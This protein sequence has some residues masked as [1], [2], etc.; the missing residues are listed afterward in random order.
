MTMAGAGT[1]GTLRSGGFSFDFLCD[2]EVFELLDDEEEDELLDE[3][4]LLELLE[5]DDGVLAFLA[6]A[7]TGPSISSSNDF[8]QPLMSL[9]ISR[10]LL[11]PSPSKWVSMFDFLLNF[12]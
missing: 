10:S 9:L 7:S 1:T 11:D 4:E 3:D 12:N 5:R 8:M 6:A 2:D